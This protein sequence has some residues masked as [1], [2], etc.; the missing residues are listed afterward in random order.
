MKT[1]I[2]KKDTHVFDAGTERKEISRH[3]RFVYM[4]DPKNF[5]D[6]IPVARFDEWFE[7]KETRWVPKPGEKFWNIEVNQFQISIVQNVWGSI[8]ILD[9]YYL[10]WQTYEQA[11]E[12]AKRCRAVL[13]DYQEEL[14]QLT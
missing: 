12:A 14:N 13:F 8:P 7:P 9:N 3:G 6:N 1:F 10:G 4:R 11:E 2:L 5:S